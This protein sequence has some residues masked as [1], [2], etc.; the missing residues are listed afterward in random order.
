MKY[1]L[2]LIVLA[3]LLAGC[4]G[5]ETTKTEFKLITWTTTRTK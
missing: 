4:G 2:I 1:L 3:V 5:A